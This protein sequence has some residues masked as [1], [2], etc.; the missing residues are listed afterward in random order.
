[1]VIGALEWSDI[2]AGLQSVR[3]AGR[4]I[5][6]ASLDHQVDADDVVYTKLILLGWAGLPGLAA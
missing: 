4:Q 6:Y 5:S 3:Q 1:M 2:R